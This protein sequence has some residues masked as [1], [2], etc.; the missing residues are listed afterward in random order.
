MNTTPR[1]HHHI[2]IALFVALVAL[3][4]S[5]AQAQNTTEPDER[6]RIGPGDVLEVRV[7]NRPQLSRESVRVDGAGSIR[8]PLV[9]GDI[10]A[11]CRTEGELAREIAARYLKYQRN[12]QVDVFIKEFQSQP[13]TVVGSVKQPGRFQLQRRARLI[14]LVALA[15][16]AG[17][18]AG[19]VVQ[20]V[21]AGGPQTC[22]EEGDAVAEEVA[23]GEGVLTFQL[24][25]VLAGEA[26]S[27]PFVRAGD[28]V[29]L[30]EAELAF[31]VGNVTRPSAVTLNQKITV[32]QAVAMAGGALP[33][34][35]VERVRVVRSTRE[36]KTEMIVNLK[37]VAKRNAEDVALLPGDIVDVPTS[38]GKRL[39]RGLVNAVAPAALSLPVAV[40]R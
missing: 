14:E 28:V 33:D 21:R 26:E 10:A 31:V 27:N 34:S 30:P 40:I 39:I 2:R 29:S 7:Y 3:A 6:Y 36:G 37:E 8:M 20:I 9:E 1:T 24:K 11:A 17:E 15:G 32:T 12:P 23:E 16:G 25:S 35:K 19:A 13:V 22:K 5:G 4:A 18:R 38:A